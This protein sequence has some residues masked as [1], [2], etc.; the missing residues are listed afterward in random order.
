M[1]EEPNT[2]ASA[3]ATKQI[4]Q[5]GGGERAEYKDIDWPNPYTLVG[6]S[7][8]AFSTHFSS[9]GTTQDPAGEVDPPLPAGPQ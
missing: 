9:K 1:A 2:G 6:D 3:K 8:L 5:E 7:A 4:N